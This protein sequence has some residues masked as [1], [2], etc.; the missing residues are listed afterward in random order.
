MMSQKIEKLLAVFEAAGCDLKQQTYD[1]RTWDQLS[2]FQ[3]QC[4]T[5]VSYMDLARYQIKIAVDK[6]QKDLLSYSEKLTNIKNKKQYYKQKCKQL[7]H[8]MQKDG[9]SRSKSRKK[10]KSKE[11]DQT[12]AKD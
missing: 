10:H 2:N 11:N 12:L 8:A 6:M 5:I 4:D 1:L 3:N 9:K 7:Q